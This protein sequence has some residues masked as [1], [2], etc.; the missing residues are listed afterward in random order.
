MGKRKG[1]NENPV[2]NLAISLGILGL[3]GGLTLALYVV[4]TNRAAVGFTF[5]CILLAGV[6]MHIGYGIT[7]TLC[8]KVAGVEGLESRLEY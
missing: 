6:G 4:C 1:T 3:I 8:L 5:S 7:L 2:K